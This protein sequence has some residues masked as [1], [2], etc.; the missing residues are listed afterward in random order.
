VYK[1]KLGAGM[2]NAWKLQ[3]EAAER[4]EGEKIE[5]EKKKKKA[6][7]GERG[8]FLFPLIGGRCC[9]NE[10]SF[11]SRTITILSPN[12]SYILSGQGDRELIQ[13]SFM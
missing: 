8:G 13:P 9:E 5:G 7:S 1:E 3:A 6:P 10:F 4:I 12:R 2:A 11:G